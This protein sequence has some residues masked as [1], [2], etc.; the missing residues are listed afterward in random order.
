[1]NFIVPFSWECHHPNCYSVHHFSEGLAK[2]HQPD[3]VF[4]SP[5]GQRE[6]APLALRDGP[7]A[8]QPSL[9]PSATEKKMGFWRTLM[10]SWWGNW[11]DIWI[12]TGFFFGFSHFKMEFGTLMFLP[13]GVLSFGHEDVILSKLDHLN[14]ESILCLVLGTMPLN[15]SMMTTFSLDAEQNPY[16]MGPDSVQLRYVCGWINS[17]KDARYFTN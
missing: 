8:L 5:R 12:F 11:M 7:M 1:M 2:N 3:M 16:R 15:G 14:I 13:K 4:P 6:D 17:G 10:G 9:W